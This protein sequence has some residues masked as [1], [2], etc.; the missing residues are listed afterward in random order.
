MIR[1]PSSF[2]F[3]A[4]MLLSCDLRRLKSACKTYAAVSMPSAT[5]NPNVGMAKGP[6]CRKGIMDAGASDSF[7]SIHD[8]ARALG[9]HG[10]WQR[11]RS[12]AEYSFRGHRS[13]WSG[14]AVEG[15]ADGKPDG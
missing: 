9:V 4:E 8:T 11:P 14:S 5:I 1:K 2:S 3:R 13:E 10:R 15:G 6:R 12:E 7:E